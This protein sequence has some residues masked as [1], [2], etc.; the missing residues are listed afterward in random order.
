MNAR[1]IRIFVH[2]DVHTG[3]QPPERGEI[4]RLLRVITST[5]YE[6]ESPDAIRSKLEEVKDVL[7]SQGLLAH[8]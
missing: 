3:I 7:R 2:P 6:G 1:K 8:R 4:A 5:V